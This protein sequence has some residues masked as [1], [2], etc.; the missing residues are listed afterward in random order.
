MMFAII[1]DVG[2]RALRTYVSCHKSKPVRLL[3]RAPGMAP[4]GFGFLDETACGLENQ[5]SC[6]DCPFFLRSSSLSRLASKRSIS[7]SAVTASLATSDT[8]PS[9][10]P[11]RT[12][13]F[14]GI[15]LTEIVM[16]PC[17]EWLSSRVLA[18]LLFC[19]RELLQLKPSSPRRA[20]LALV[21]SAAASR[22]SGLCGMGRSDG[23]CLRRQLPGSWLG[24]ALGRWRPRD[25]CAHFSHSHR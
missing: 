9:L 8:K 25:V 1:T 24:S 22:E 23:R 19:H 16:L 2:R 4:R 14:E 5:F 18:R 12:P 20:L 7:S 21:T 3:G 10:P 6:R 17:M 11:A 15:S 13:M